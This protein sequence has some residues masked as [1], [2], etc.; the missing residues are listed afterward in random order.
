MKVAS[1]GLPSWLGLPG[2]YG[3]MGCKGGPST[4]SGLISKGWKPRS[5]DR[6]RGPQGP[7][8]ASPDLPRQESLT[9]T[10]PG[11]PPPQPAACDMGPQG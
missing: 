2:F 1:P 4:T 10:V 11:R 3:N 7:E 8:D 9:L 5:E 6:K